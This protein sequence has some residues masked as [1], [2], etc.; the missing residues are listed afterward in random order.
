VRTSDKILALL[1]VYL[2]IFTVTMV[3]IFCLKGAI[4]DTLVQYTM[5]AGGV[6]SVA[7]AAIKIVKVSNGDGKDEE[8][9]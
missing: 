5:G 3:V 7:L 8:D 4:P 1:G 6:E 9:E 2:L